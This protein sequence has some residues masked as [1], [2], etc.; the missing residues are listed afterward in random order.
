MKEQTHARWTAARLAA[1]L[2]DLGGAALAELVAHAAGCRVCAREERMLS[3]LDR[4][5]EPQ[6]R[7]QGRAVIRADGG[8]VEVACSEQGVR[9]VRL[10]LAG[11]RHAASAA[12]AGPPRG[13]SPLLQQAGREIE[14]YL[15][16]RLTSFTVPVDL[17]GLTTFQREVLEATR[18]VPRGSV[19]TYAELARRIGHPRAQRAVGAAL[20]R[21][22]VPLI[23]PC[24]RVV[25]SG[26]ELGEYSG[27]GP[28]VK[29]RLL[30]LEGVA[31]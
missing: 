17:R 23:V 19:V 10:D 27:G 7:S 8:T 12:A 30:Q 24:H 6:S 1:A 9:S 4:V 26:G 2:G 21:N 31:M 22:P 11:S 15:A 20:K 16:G 29:R 28:A 18:Q 25:R 13:V 3:L 14:E 5:T